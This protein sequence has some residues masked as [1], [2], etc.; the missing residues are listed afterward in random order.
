MII[1]C[2]KLDACAKENQVRGAV[3]RR[4]YLRAIEEARD[5]IDYGANNNE[6]YSRTYLDKNIQIIS[7]TKPL[8]KT[9]ML[10]DAIKRLETETKNNLKTLKDQQGKSYQELQEEI[11]KSQTEAKRQVDLL[12][13]DFSALQKRL[14]NQI[15]VIMPE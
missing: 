7:D 6:T 8:F 3:E 9:S 1:I 15:A 11:R 13:Q 5:S 2:D 10:N 12:K 4:T 14:E